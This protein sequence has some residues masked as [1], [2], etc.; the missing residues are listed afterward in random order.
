MDNGMRNAF[1]SLMDAKIP[2]FIIDLFM[3]I[4]DGWLQIIQF[5]VG[6]YYNF[7]I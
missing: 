1:V 7:V 6:N 3:R 4:Y 5:V 2:V